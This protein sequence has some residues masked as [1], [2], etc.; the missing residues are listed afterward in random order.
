M[1][2]ITFFFITFFLDGG[3]DTESWYDVSTPL[4]REHFPDR[5]TNPSFDCEGKRSEIG[6]ME[7]I[8]LVAGHPRGHA[9]ILSLNGNASLSYRAYG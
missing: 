7:P 3:V 4:P 5:R 2:T 6:S 8:D 9:A 1:P